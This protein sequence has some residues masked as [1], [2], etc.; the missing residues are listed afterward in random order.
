[1]TTNIEGQL[2]PY[3]LELVD[4]YKASL[5]DD[6]R[7]QPISPRGADDEEYS[8][9]LIVRE[10]IY[11][12]FCVEGGEYADTHKKI[13]NDK[14][15]VFGFVCGAVGT[16]AVTAGLSI[17]VAVVTAAVALVLRVTTTIGVNSLCRYASKFGLEE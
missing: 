15:L 14:E 12:F 16:A 2:S 1:M 4:V 8:L 6:A 13:K 9:F 11:K 10:E 7:I 17:P 5:R 3:F